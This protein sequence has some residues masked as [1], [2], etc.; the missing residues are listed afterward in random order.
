MP[1]VPESNTKIMCTTATQKPTV[2]T[3]AY[4]RIMTTSHH[5]A[6]A[7]VATSAIP[8]SKS[9]SYGPNICPKIRPSGELIFVKR[10]TYQW[11]GTSGKD[12][13][14]VGEERAVTRATCEE[15]SRGVT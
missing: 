1:Y 3:V 5:P 6:V 2:C 15:E 13:I 12:G 11:F 7:D 10:S 14:D 8:L 4:P 9:S